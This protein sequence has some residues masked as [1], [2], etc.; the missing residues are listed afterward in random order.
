MINKISQKGVPLSGRNA[1]LAPNQPVAGKVRFDQADFDSR[2]S[3]IDAVD[4]S[5]PLL[6]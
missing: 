4:G 3:A 1:R 2:Q 5:P 6:R